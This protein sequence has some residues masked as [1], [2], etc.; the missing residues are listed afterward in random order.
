[1]GSNYPK[2]PSQFREE[3]RNG[4][5]KRSTNGI[6]PGYVQ[7]NLVIIPQKYALDF[8]IFCF[9]NPKPCPVLEILDPGNPIIKDIAQKADVRTDL[10]MYRIYKEGELIKETEDIKKFWDDDLVS[11]LIGCSYTFEEAL[12]RG[13]VPIKNYMD[14]KDPPVYITSVECV[15]SGIFSGP[16][17]VTMRP[18]QADL[19]SRAVK[20]TSHFP[21]AHGTP[22]NIGKPELLGIYDLNKID[23]GEKHFSQEPFVMKFPSFGHAV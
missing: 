8:T 9:R 17:V 11:Y 18:V 13:G 7:A 21:K 5:W 12:V 23:F 2:N 22:V 10:P 15:P 20:I 14:K 6:C 4:L 16:L 19:I 1:M 3:V